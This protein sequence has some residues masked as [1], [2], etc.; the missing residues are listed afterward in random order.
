VPKR[1]IGPGLV[2][3][4]VSGGSQVEERDT[5]LLRSPHPSHLFTFT[6]LSLCL[7]GSLVLLH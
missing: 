7:Q 5:K 3:L 1:D 4:S 2:P 6:S